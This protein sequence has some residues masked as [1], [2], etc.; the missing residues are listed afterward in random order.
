MSRW[1]EL[2][3]DLVDIGPP[4]YV[5]LDRKPENSCEIRTAASEKCGIMIRLEVLKR[6]TESE[7]LPFEDGSPNS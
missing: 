3:G 4:H 7:M 1:Y 6:S 5:A 2:G